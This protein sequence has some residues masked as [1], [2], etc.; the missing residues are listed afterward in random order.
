MSNANTGGG[1]PKLVRDKIPDIIIADGKTPNIRVLEDESE[2]RYVLLR[3][4]VEEAIELNE[5]AGRRNVAEEIA[6]VL[7]VLDELTLIFGITPEQIKKIQDDKREARGGFSLR[8]LM[9]EPAE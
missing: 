7:E 4:V 1:Y 5:V 2:F 9:L 3:K 8:I 6:D